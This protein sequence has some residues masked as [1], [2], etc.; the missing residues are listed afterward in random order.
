MQATSGMSLPEATLY[1]NGGAR[2]PSLPRPWLALDF[3]QL[4]TMAYVA[5]CEWWPRNLFPL[6]VPSDWVRPGRPLNSARRH[7]RV[8]IP[9]LCPTCFLG[10]PPCPLSSSVIVVDFPWLVERTFFFCCCSQK[11]DCNFHF[12]NASLRLR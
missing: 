12:A 8:H 3:R 4:S 10:G 2:V 6:A 1:S 11:G 9:L 5:L 7:T